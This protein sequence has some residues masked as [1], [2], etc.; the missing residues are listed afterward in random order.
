MNYP[1]EH[2]SQPEH[3]RYKHLKVRGPGEE[4]LNRD[5]LVHQDLRNEIMSGASDIDSYTRHKPANKIAGGLV[6]GWAILSC[7]AVCYWIIS[8]PFIRSFATKLT[9]PSV[10]VATN[11]EAGNTDA[12]NAATSVASAETETSNDIEQPST[13]DTTDSNIDILAASSS[14]N[15]TDA[16][17]DS[18]NQNDDDIRLNKL[19]ELSDSSTLNQESNTQTSADTVSGTIT[20]QTYSASMFSHPSN[21]GASET[22]VPRG[23]TVSLLGTH[24]DWIE[25]RVIET[26]EVGYMHRSLLSLP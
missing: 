21:T 5:H 14:T 16:T 12:N 10:N 9:T 3:L 20:I 22:P 26:N 13:V 11:S 1:P 15:T 7:I 6:R 8:S 2:P 23:T 18:V 19:P 17:S 24:N 25:I 4:H